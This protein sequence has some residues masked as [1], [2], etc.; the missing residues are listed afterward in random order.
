DEIRLVAEG[1]IERRMQGC[2]VRRA[3]LEVVLQRVGRICITAWN[4]AVV[5]ITG[6][7]HRCRYPA[8]SVINMPV[9]ENGLRYGRLC[10]NREMEVAAGMESIGNRVLDMHRKTRSYFGGLPNCFLSRRPLKR[11]IAEV[12]LECRQV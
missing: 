3:K 5:P 10:G 1:P 8:L 6:L 9:P 7:L 12:F 4:E 2:G 11:L